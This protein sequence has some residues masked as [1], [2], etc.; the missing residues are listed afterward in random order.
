MSHAS[1]PRCKQFTINDPNACILDYRQLKVTIQTK[2]CVPLPNI[3]ELERVF[4]G[5]GSC[6]VEQIGASNQYLIRYRSPNSGLFASKQ[7]NQKSFAE[8]KISQL[9]YGWTTYCSSL[10]YPSSSP[11]SQ[12]HQGVKCEKVHAFKEQSDAF[13]PTGNAQTDQHSFYRFKTYRARHCRDSQFVADLDFINMEGITLTSTAQT[14]TRKAPPPPMSPQCTPPPS[15]RSP[16]RSPHRAA[17]DSHS[18]HIPPSRQPPPPPPQPP[19]SSLLSPQKAKVAKLKCVAGAVDQETLELR[20]KQLLAKDLLLQQLNNGE[21]PNLKILKPNIAAGASSIYPHLQTGQRRVSPPRTPP[22]PSVKAI[23][24]TQQHQAQDNKHKN[25]EEVSPD[26]EIAP[27]V[28]SSR[29]TLFHA[30]MHHSDSDSEDGDGSV[31]STDDSCGALVTSMLAT[32]ISTTENVNRLNCSSKNKQSV[33]V[34]HPNSKDNAV[35]SSNDWNDINEDDNDASYDSSASDSESPQA[36]RDGTTN[37]QQQ[38]PDTKS[39]ACAQQFRSKRRQRMQQKRLQLQAQPQKKMVEVTQIDDGGG[40]KEKEKVD[41]EAKEAETEVVEVGPNS[42]PPPSHNL[43]D[44]QSDEKD[45]LSLPSLPDKTR[46]EKNDQAVQLSCAASSGPLFSPR[47][48]TGKSD[49]TESSISSAE[50][51]ALTSAK[52]LL[53]PN[54]MKH[55]SRVPLIDLS[56]RN[57]TYQFTRPNPQ[58][59]PAAAAAT[60]STT[61]FNAGAQ[62]SLFSQSLNSQS[63]NLPSNLSSYYNYSAR[64]QPFRPMNSALFTGN[65]VNAAPTTTT[66]TAARSVTTPATTAATS[67][68]ATAVTTKLAQTPQP[69]NQYGF[70]YN[71]KFP[72]PTS[73]E[74]Y[75]WLCYHFASDNKGACRDGKVCPWRHYDFM[76]RADVVTAWHPDNIPEAPLNS[77][78][79]ETAKNVKQA[80]EAKFPWLRQLN[81]AQDKKLAKA[82]AIQ[83]TKT[84]TKKA[85]LNPYMNIPTPPSI[86][87]QRVE[88]WK[89]LTNEK[90]TKSP[91]CSRR[92]ILTEKKTEIEKVEDDES[93]HEEADDEVTL[94]MADV[95]ENATESEDE[96]E[97]PVLQ[98]KLEFEE[99]DTIYALMTPFRL[100]ENKKINYYVIG[101]LVSKEL[102]KLKAKIEQQ[103]L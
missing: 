36:N 35:R 90:K 63:L 62:S 30:P 29:S 38:P 52:A 34:D 8:W 103:K 53:S 1:F 79:M 93:K 17:N 7:L 81:A 15:Q 101:N 13:V 58:C 51:V 80:R 61:W 73:V 83:T 20:Q 86:K 69:H 95:N 47:P 76:A 78:K 23:Q 18:R 72:P 6:E 66:M 99:L 96:C 84:K 91:L 25:K 42:A 94:A 75:F 56:K 49:R 74:D 9:K 5:Y 64:Q 21:S 46:Q 22:P 77:S 82:L 41:Q 33:T 87:R 16:H 14:E 100:S 32:K 55:L 26:D 70:E 68:T 10:F 88:N 12:C 4:G 85:Q 54:G 45:A 98:S 43:T 50:K 57:V 3:V 59:A 37:V 31:S 27:S 71:Y 28:R 11:L 39:V 92:K 97:S 44:T 102:E 48:Q 89:R 67:T 2:A 19:S 40:G 60:A 24:A 65:A